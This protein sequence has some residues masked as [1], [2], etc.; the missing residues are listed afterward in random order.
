MFSKG[1]YVVYGHNG[2]CRIEDIANPGFSGVDKKKMYYILQPLE[3]DGSRIYSPIESHKVLMRHVMK[4][5][6]A[7]ELIENIPLVKE[8]WVSN[9]KMREESYKTAMRTC[10]PKE[11]VKIIK[12]L[13]VRRKDRMAQGKK[14]TT[15]DDRYL[16]LAEDNLYSEL[17]FAL[18]K[19][20]CEMED[21]ITARI[22]KQKI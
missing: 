5:Q 12:T 19:D 18:G 3:T 2:I 21:Y 20:K 4:A 22:G 15:T 10:E 7:E 17:G 13:Y 6:E 11:W 9:E 8:L 1:E 16:K 14:I